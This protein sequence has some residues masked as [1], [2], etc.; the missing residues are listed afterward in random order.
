MAFY[1]LF[2]TIGYYR[3]L[4][5]FLK[6]ISIFGAT[7]SVGSN[8]CEIILRNQSRYKVIVLSANKNYKKLAMYSKKLKPKYAIIRDQKLYKSLL[9]RIKW[10]LHEMFMWRR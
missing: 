6:K 8:A 7:G 2:S 10:Q 3:F 9:E 5:V 1:L 4:G